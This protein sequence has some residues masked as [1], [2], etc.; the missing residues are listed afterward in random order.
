MNLPFYLARNVARSG[1]R[2]VSRA[3]IIIAAV[4]VAL[5]MTTMVLASAMISGFKTEISD[6]VFSF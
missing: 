5:S 3:I 6:K 1:S 4:A 2:S